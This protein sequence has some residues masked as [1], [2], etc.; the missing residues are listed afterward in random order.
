MAARPQWPETQH[1][2]INRAA[3]NE[4][5]YQPSPQI[6][7]NNLASIQSIHET[8]KADYPAIYLSNAAERKRPR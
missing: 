4:P 5:H 3:I 1:I 7:I 8:P 6:S 2:T